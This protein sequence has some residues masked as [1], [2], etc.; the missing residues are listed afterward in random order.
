MPNKPYALVFGDEK[1]AINEGRA[2]PCRS[3]ARMRVRAGG[4]HLN[5]MSGKIKIPHDESQN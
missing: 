5:G 1:Y 3:T 4:A 2:G